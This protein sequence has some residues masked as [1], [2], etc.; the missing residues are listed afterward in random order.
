MAKFRDAGGKDWTVRVTVGRLQALKDE[1]G[2]D[3]RDA[4]KVEGNTVAEA[5]GDP[6]RAGQ[7][8]WVLC[9]DDA[10]QAGLTQERFFDLFDGDVYRAAVEAV[11]AATFDFFHGRSAGQKAGAAF[12][13][14]AEK[15][16]QGMGRV[17]DR[18]TESLTSGGSGTN[19]AA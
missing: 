11:W 12:R 14:G 17:W 2:I 5:L 6:F 18:V 1:C 7:L 3:L 13:T 9:G 15:L 10:E 16:D 19:S 8:L 4:L